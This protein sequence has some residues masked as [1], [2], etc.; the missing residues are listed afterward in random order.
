MQSQNKQLPWTAADVK[1]KQIDFLLLLTFQEWS[2]ADVSHL[3][4]EYV[5]ILKNTRSLQ[6]IIYWALQSQSKATP[7]TLLSFLNIFVS[8]LR[9]LGLSHKG[10]VSALS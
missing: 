7:L 9:K 1:T 5:Q 10:K 3:R 8:F 4:V 6:P 2:T